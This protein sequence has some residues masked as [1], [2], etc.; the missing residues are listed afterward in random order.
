MSAALA[1]Q[2]L[3]AVCIMRM[4]GH[5]QQLQDPS[6]AFIDTTG[7]LGPLKP[8]KNVARAKIKWL[9]VMVMT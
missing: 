6:T 1:A 4:T 7:D 8:A 5:Y 3:F 9:H 2:C